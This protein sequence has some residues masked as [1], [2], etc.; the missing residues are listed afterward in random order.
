MPEGGSLIKL[1][2]NAALVIVTPNEKWMEEA[3]NL[4]LGEIS[5][6]MEKIEALM[7]TKNKTYRHPVM[8]INVP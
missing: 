6:Y 1:A 8:N 2:N 7:L 5:T 3:A 4:N